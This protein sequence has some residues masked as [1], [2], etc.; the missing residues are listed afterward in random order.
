MKIK[1][2]F[3]LIMIQEP[4]AATGDDSVVTVISGFE[5]EQL[6]LRNYQVTLESSTAGIT[7]TATE[8]GLQL[9]STSD[10]VYVSGKVRDIYINSKQKQVMLIATDRQS[11]F[12][13]QLAIIPYKS[14][15][16]TQTSIWW[17]N[18]TQDIVPNHFQHSP[19]PAV[20]VC[21]QCT[22]FPIEFVV[23]SVNVNV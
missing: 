20:M 15:V 2:D 14:E 16:L 19:D 3:Q 21:Q 6:R 11:A 17:F 9:P 5:K 4:T 22:I 12:D 10:W 18:Q 1:I 13:R 8:L 23:R 7:T